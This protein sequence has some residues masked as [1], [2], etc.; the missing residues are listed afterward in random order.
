MNLLHLLKLK[1]F[2]LAKLKPS[3][4]TK[5]KDSNNVIKILKGSHFVIHFFEFNFKYLLFN[6]IEV[7]TLKLIT[8]KNEI[9]LKSAKL[10][11]KFS[12]SAA[13]LND[14]D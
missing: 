3:I 9:N 1:Q 11:A 12:I 14:A 10:R 2:L 7:N 6:D 8:L 4:T 13:T 5:T